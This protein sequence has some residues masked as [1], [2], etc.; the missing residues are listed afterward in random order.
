MTC[1]AQ[2]CCRACNLG[3]MHAK[4]NYVTLSCAAAVLQFFLCPLLLMRG[5]LPRLLSCVL[6]ALALSYYHYLS[7]L[8]G[9]TLAA[10]DKPC[11]PAQRHGVRLVVAR[12]MHA[13][14]M[15][16]TID[17][18]AQHAAG[19]VQLIAA[20]LTGRSD[21]KARTHCTASCNSLCAQHAT[22]ACRN[23]CCAPCAGYSPLP[24]LEHT[25]VF[26]WPIAG[27]LLITPLALLTGF[28]PTR[29]TLNIYFGH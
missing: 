1:L 10:T 22:R 11:P 29:F 21:L 28:N 13:C 23:G 12:G 19:K 9:H 4:V 16:G 27:I 7:F 17:Q 20:C 25:E 14:A 6:Y 8:G 24:F 18:G 26:L 2:Q 15:H 3:A 5:F